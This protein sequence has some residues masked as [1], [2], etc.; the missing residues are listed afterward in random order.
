MRPDNRIWVFTH[1]FS[2][3]CCTNF[4]D[5]AGFHY[6]G[7]TTVTGPT[8]V[9]FVGELFRLTAGT[10]EQALIHGSNAYAAADWCEYFPRHTFN[11]LPSWL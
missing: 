6:G 1:V 11:L 5:N 9:G 3:D 7:P 8:G 10:F 4:A 2:S